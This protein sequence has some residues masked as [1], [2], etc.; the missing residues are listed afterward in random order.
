MRYNKYFD[1]FHLKQFKLNRLLTNYK[2]SNNAENPNRI[3][4]S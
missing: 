2:L 3:G 1:F 4:K